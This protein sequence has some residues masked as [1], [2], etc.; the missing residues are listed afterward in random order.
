M[1]AKEIALNMKF[2][3]LNKADLARKLSMS[4]A[5]VTQL[6]NLLKLP[7]ELIGK[8][9]EVGDY[10]ERRHVTERM[11]RRTVDRRMSP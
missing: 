9:E 6:L 1:Q 8:V 2:K 3:D 11:L 4:R 7:D 10:W 5:R